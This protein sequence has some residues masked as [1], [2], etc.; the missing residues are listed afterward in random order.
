MVDSVQDSRFKGFLRP[1]TPPPPIEGTAWIDFLHDLVTGLT[2]LDGSLVRP[3]WQ[4]QPPVTPA[5]TVD[6]CAVGATTSES[7]WQPV[8][9]HVAD[10]PANPDGYDIFQRMETTDVLASFYGPNGQ[11]YADIFRD[12]L[13]IDQNHA[14]LRAMS[15]C[16]VEVSSVS[17]GP[18]LFRQQWRN[19]ND[20]HFVVRR[21]IRR[22]YQV[23]TLLRSTGTITANAPFDEERTLENDYDTDRGPSLQPVKGSKS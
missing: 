1:N 8:F 13:F 12:G 7:D 16:I 2:G 10:D 23:R 3:R 21:E 18:E 14:P 5:V 22:I 20:I 11:T 17:V 9:F 4:Q 15:A 6:W 19:R